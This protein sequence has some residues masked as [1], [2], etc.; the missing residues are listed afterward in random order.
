M[1]EKLSEKNLI[2]R[3]EVIRC[4]LA[5]NM[6]EV[7]RETAYTEIDNLIQERRA[8]DVMRSLPSEEYIEKPCPFCFQN[9]G[10]SSDHSRGEWIRV[11]DEGN[12][13]ASFKCDLCCGS[14]KIYTKRGN[15]A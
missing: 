15:D 10:H 4:L 9:D 12:Y 13:G 1:S 11:N 7:H 2:E 3:L 8:C 6:E 14:R 5:P